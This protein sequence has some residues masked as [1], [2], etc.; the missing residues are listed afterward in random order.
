MRIRKALPDDS[1]SIANI[2]IASWQ[3]AYQ[4]IIPTERLL[5]MNVAHTTE[6]FRE[7][8]VRGIEDIYVAEIASQIVGFFTV[9]AYRDTDIV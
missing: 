9:G 1:Q 5:A 6:C 3:N 8:I 7:N 2:H 4:S